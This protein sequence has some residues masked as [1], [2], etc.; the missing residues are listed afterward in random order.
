MEILE[1]SMVNDADNEVLDY[2]YDQYY[3][4]IHLPSFSQRAI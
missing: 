3:L 4:S 1:V 2:E